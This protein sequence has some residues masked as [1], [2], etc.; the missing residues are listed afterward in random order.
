MMNS[1]YKEKREYPRFQ[2]S[3]PVS[4]TA[5]DLGETSRTQTYDISAEGLGI[6]ADKELPIGALLKLRLIMSDNGEE[7]PRN[8]KVIWSKNISNGKFR[9]GIKIDEPTLKPIVIVLRTIDNNLKN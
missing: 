7:I 2:I 5:V 3:V 1:D 4:V 8:G 6:I 9:T